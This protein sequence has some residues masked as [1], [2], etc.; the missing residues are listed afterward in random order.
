M[1]TQ[2]PSGEPSSQSRAA[3]IVADAAK[4]GMTE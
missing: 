1:D 3:S 2:S 4:A